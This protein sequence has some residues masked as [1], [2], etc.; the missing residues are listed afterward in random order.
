MLFR[1]LFSL[2]TF[3]CQAAYC[4]S[5]MQSK[6]S[7]ESSGDIFSTEET[8]WRSEIT[9][10]KLQLISNTGCVKSSRPTLMHYN[11]RQRWANFHNFFTKIHNG[12][13]KEVWIKTLASPQICCRTT[14]WKVSGHQHSFTFILARIVRFMSGSICFMSFCLFMFSSWWWRHC[15]IIAIFCL[16]HYSF[17]SVMKINVWQAL[18]NAQL[19]HP[20]TS[21]IHDL[22]HAYV[23]M[24]DILSCT[25]CK[26]ICR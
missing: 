11:F 18:N 13:V 1:F 4:S 6:L 21:G 17:L 12:S 8:Y 16:M 19:T 10:F 5:H 7:H 15:D 22:K 23:T 14:L 25:W 20:L 9:S 24:T 2:V 3:H 26:L